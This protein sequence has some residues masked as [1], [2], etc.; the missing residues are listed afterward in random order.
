MPED[1]ALEANSQCQAQKIQEE[2]APSRVV[3]GFLTQEDRTIWMALRR[4]KNEFIAAVGT[5]IFQ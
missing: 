5:R 4:T 2:Q 1:R 3:V